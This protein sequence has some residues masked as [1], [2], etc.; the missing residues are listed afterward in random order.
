V[1]FDTREAGNV[2]IALN[3]GEPKTDA[4]SWA[5]FLGRFGLKVWIRKLERE[6]I[7]IKHYRQS[8]KRIG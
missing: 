6:S 3:Q 8:D 7:N 4:K 5:S 1:Y 2:I